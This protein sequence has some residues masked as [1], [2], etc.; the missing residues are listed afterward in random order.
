MQPKPAVASEAPLLA[1]K[2]CLEPARGVAAE[3]LI[4]HVRP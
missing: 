3:A 1:A 4:K 2:N